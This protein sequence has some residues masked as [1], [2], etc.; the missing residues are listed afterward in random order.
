MEERPIDETRRILRLRELS[1]LD[2]PPD[3]RFDRIVEI[4]G[5]FFPGL[6][7][8]IAFVDDRRVWAK[9]TEK[10]KQCEYSREQSFCGTAV[11][12]GEQLLLEDTLKENRFLH[13]GAVRK[14]GIRFYANRL[15]YT[16]DG[17]VVGSV[18][19]RGMEPRKFSKDDEI[20]FDLIGAMTNELLAEIEEEESTLSAEANESETL[21]ELRI[22]G[23]FF[24]ESPVPM[25]V[26]NGEDLHYV[27]INRAALS[28]LG[29]TRASVLGGQL[30]DQLDGNSESLVHQFKIQLEFR[31]KTAPIELT[32]KSDSGRERI[33]SVVGQLIENGGIN[34]VLVYFHDVTRA[35]TRERKTRWL[36]EGTS[37]YTGGDFFRF[38]CE[39]V[40][41]MTGASLVTI[42]RLVGRNRI[43]PLCL[44]H[45]GRFMPTQ[46]V[47]ITGAPCERVLRG[48][49]VFIGDN[50]VTAT[51]SDRY[52]EMGLRSFSGVPIRGA[53]QEIL[54]HL[55]ILG[56]SAMQ[57]D[58][59]REAMLTAISS[60]IASEILRADAEA[61]KRDDLKRAKLLQ[62]ISREIR[63]SLKPDR[64]LATAA[65][66]IGVAFRVSRC[67]IYLFDESGQDQKIRLSPVAEYLAPEV[68]TSKSNELELGTDSI[69]AKVVTEDEPL[70]IDDFRKEVLSAETVKMFETEDIVSVSAVRISN[71]TLASGLIVLQ[72]C[73]DPRGWRRQDIV[74]LESIADQLGIGLAHAKA[75]VSEKQRAAELLEA[76]EKALAA[77]NAKG[78]FL[79]RMSHELR[80]P[81]NS[82]LG[83]SKL[84]ESDADITENHLETLRIINRSG[85]HLLS[86]I[87][88][89]LEMSKIEAGQTEVESETVNL[90][91]MID[92]IGDMFQFRAEVNDLDFVIE[93]AADLPE[94]ILSDEKKLRQI[95]TNLLGNAYKFTRSG[96]VQLTVTRFGEMLSF[97]VSDTGCGI[98][99]EE[100]PKLF[101]VFSQ[102]HEGR[103]TSEGTGLGLAISKGFVELLGGKIEVSSV[104]GEGTAFSFYVPLVESVAPDQQGKRLTADSVIGIKEGGAK[105]LIADDQ[106]ENRLFLKRFLT[107][108]GFQIVEAV[109]GQHAVEVTESERPDGIL[110]DIRMPVMDGIGATQAL[111]KSGYDK[112]IIALTGN[113][114]EEDRRFALKSGCSAFL[115]K[116]VDFDSL[117]RTLQEQLP[118]E[119]DIAASDTLIV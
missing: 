1:I 25:A 97:T 51:S 52:A 11:R 95:L 77:S 3:P 107:R 30:F 35:R 99:A 94:W 108:L 78:E 21:T 46:E 4:A 53:S 87:S 19:L 75:L 14:A 111:R 118:L 16:L 82:I 101:M 17:T 22:F 79:A 80:T 117:L 113:A 6:Q 32:I 68:S 85:E 90:T 48:E 96:R 57:P 61:F 89:V 42:S 29:R 66:E 58:P 116:P 100:I 38:C 31:Q 92:T 23:D 37:A 55:A 72:Q 33:A 112:P 81:L 73:G 60:R 40:A 44:W 39:S 10:K 71:R 93:R 15:L 54:G 43:N 88:D 91:E 62:R 65:E 63:K 83:F 28:L 86:L 76:Q 106:F 102:T 7:C 104:L 70:V 27:Q 5:R 105:L 41:R 20:N 84:L 47:D 13:L 64:I 119:F 109:D 69:F 74:L 18:C 98:A 26:L 49:T 9:A 24:T 34:Y 56:E 110:M 50:L 103:H 67:Q 12:L 2:S 59:D 114:F 8:A 36:F 45:N 115:A